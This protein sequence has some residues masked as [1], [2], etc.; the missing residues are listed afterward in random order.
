MD[1]EGLGIA[2]IDQL[3]ARELIHDVSDL[4]R[5]TVDNLLD[6]EKFGQRSVENLIG[7][8]ERSKGAKLWRLLHGLGIPH[9]GTAT[10]RELEKHYLGLE[11][12]RSA[13]REELLAI[14]GIGEIMAQS[15]ENFFAFEANQR[16]IERLE[17]VRVNTRS[18]SILKGSSGSLEGK[19]FVITGTLPSLTRQASKNLIEDAGGKVTESP[20]TR[21]SYLLV[22]EF[23]GSK[24]AKAEALGIPIIDEAGLQKLLD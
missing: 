16:I 13:S 7:A 1:I 22:G 9:V 18:Q 8:I 15:I 6:L 23:P 14:D 4:Y 12:L 5:L 10:A 24:Q 20:S 2:V 11:E 3:V 17:A 19:T 21:T